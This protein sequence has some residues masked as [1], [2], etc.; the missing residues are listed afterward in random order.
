MDALGHAAGSYT[1]GGVRYRASVYETGI[2]GQVLSR[3]EGAGQY[4][5]NAPLTRYYR[6]GGRAMSEVS[7]DGTHNVGYPAMNEERA[8]LLSCV[9]AS[10]LPLFAIVDLHLIV[11]QATHRSSAARS[12]R[13]ISITSFFGR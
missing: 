2:D 8:F 3:R 7:N 6:F 13:K 12:R 10:A 4:A 9:P 11:A 5:G 1:R